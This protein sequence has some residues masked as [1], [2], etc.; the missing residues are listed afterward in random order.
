MTES[1]YPERPILLVD[2]D[3]NTLNSFSIVLR[4]Q[5]ISNVITCQ[6]PREV[7]GILNHQ[8]VEVVLLDMVMPELSGR[9]LLARLTEDHPDL[10]V[11]MVT[12][13][14]EVETAVECMRG[15]A[16][17]YILKPVKKERLYASV[18][19]ALEVRSLRRENA[20]LTRRILTHELDMPEAF[21]DILTL[22]PRMQAIFQYCEAIAAGRQPV[23]ITGETGTGKELIA[24]ALHRASRR[25]GR[26]VAVN[27]AGLDDSM[28]SDTLFG[29]RKG[30]FTGADAARKG[31]IEQATGG[32]LFLDEIGDLAPSSQVRILRLLQERE[33]YP[34]GSDVARPTDARILVATHRDLEAMFHAGAFRKDLYYRLRAHHIHIPALRER[35]EDLSLLVDAF[36]VEAAEEL[37]KNPPRYPGELI[38]LLGAYSFPGNVRELR[39]MV[40]D[41]VTR[42]RSKMLS[43]RVFRDS[44]SLLEEPGALAE[45]NDPEHVPMSWAAGMTVLPFLKDATQ[46]LISEALRRSNQNQRVAARLLGISHQ[47]L[48][49]RLK[50]AERGE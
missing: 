19:R 7:Q 47:S 43:T 5:G 22:S 45:K 12:G 2:D 25:K 33:Y 34:L 10:P 21:T 15:G 46:T 50:R 32:T 1:R 40:F 9:D 26:F 48:N 28:F 27:V 23:L 37:G 17:D 16:F 18:C 11:I 39:S 36:I 3:I 8:E 14:N 49:K 42:H 30:A 6:D 24:R 41:A 20:D 4:A 29:H 31:L 13:V 38:T 44:M 35:R